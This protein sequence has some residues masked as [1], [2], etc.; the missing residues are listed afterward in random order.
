VIVVFVLRVFG[1]L[2]GVGQLAL[3]TRLKKLNSS[4]WETG[5][6]VFLFSY[7]IDDTTGK[8]YRFNTLAAR[9]GWAYIHRARVGLVLRLS[10]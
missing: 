4:I 3:H 2:A 10:G 9:G 7:N 8:V 5:L 6:P 1:H